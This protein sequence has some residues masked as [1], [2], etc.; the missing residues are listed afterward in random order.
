[1][2]DFQLNYNTYIY[3]KDKISLVLI[4]YKI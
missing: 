3:T 2:Q 1:M 4:T